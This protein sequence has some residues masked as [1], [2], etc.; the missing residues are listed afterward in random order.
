MQLTNKKSFFL[1]AVTVLLA[2]GCAKENLTAPAVESGRLVAR[3]EGALS[4]R[5]SFDSREGAFTWT[6]GDE[7]AIHYSSG[8]YVTFP[9]NPSNGTLDVTAPVSGAIRDKYAVYPASSVVASAAGSPLKIVFPAS[10]DISDKLDQPDFAPLP[11]VAINDDART[12]LDFYHVGGLVRL[13]LDGASS[14]AQRID[15]V[16]DKAVTGEFEVTFMGGKPYVLAGTPTSSNATVSF[17]LAGSGA[18][19]GDRTE[20]VVLNVPVPCGVYE[21]VRLN[22]YDASDNLLSSQEFSLPQGRLN[23]ERHQGKRLHFYDNYCTPLTLEAVEAG[24]IDVSNYSNPVQYRIN[25]GSWID[26]AVNENPTI[27]VAPGDV[28]QFRGDNSRYIQKFVTCNARCY[29]YGNIMSMV[30]AEGFPSCTELTGSAVFESFFEGNATLFNHPVRKLLLPATTL[31]NCCYESL[32]E[33]CSNLTV[34]PELPATILADNC[35]SYMFKDCTSLTIAPELPATSVTECCYYYMFSGCTSLST[36]PELPATTIARGSYSGMFKN[37]ISLTTAPELPA[38]T[39][40]YGAYGD[41][42]CGCTS[43]TT[44]P[45]LPATTI[46][47]DCYMYMFKGCTSLTTAPERLPA[48]TMYTYCYYG[49]FQGC[50]SL[51]TA[52][53]LPATTLKSGCYGAMFQD[54]TNLNY[55]K[56]LSTGSGR[57]YTDSWVEGVAAAGTFVKKSGVSWGEG[58]DGIP[59]GWEI[60]E[61]SE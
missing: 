47:E 45:D 42:F 22:T 51:T 44:A 16:F 59:S 46:E 53:E 6:E 41:M 32:F 34:A 8:S 57:W 13:T 61:A 60:Q 5:T 3:I 18:S 21:S 7:L 19:L 33:G 26:I 14:S 28:V 30:S 24:T 35:Y 17:I 38:T 25:G 56:C 15:V 48:T 50:I 43:L 10:F 1:L 54:C 4:T 40:D 2:G 29:V 12:D 23:M 49:M 31:T 27:T 52:P 39:L 11:M 36:A 58:N 55:I 20:P 37:C 9:I